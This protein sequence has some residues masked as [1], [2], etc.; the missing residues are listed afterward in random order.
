MNVLV[1]GGELYLGD[2]TDAFMFQPTYGLEPDEVDDGL[3][4]VAT[5]VQTS[6]G[7]RTLRKYGAGTLILSNVDYTGEDGTGDTSAQFEWQVREGTLL[8][9]DP[10]SASFRGFSVYNG[11]TLG[12]NE[13]IRIEAGGQLLVDG[14]TGDPATINPGAS[15][16]TLTADTDTVDFHD[17]ARLYIEVDDYNYAD[18]FDV[19]GFLDLTAGDDILKLVS[20]GFYGA[21]NGSYIISE[22]GSLNGE[23]NTVDVSELGLFGTTEGVDWTIDYGSGTSDVITFTVFNGTQVPEP[24]TLAVFGIGL[25]GVALR[26][27]RL[28]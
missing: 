20:V 1:R 17:D 12:G 14:N 3:D 22:Y 6:T 19:T 5:P 25:A 24:M 18:R 10:G 2:A 8:Y 23:F 27:R 15:I 16:G 13:T 7:D 28:A 21:F 26:R 4:A 11:A 9:N